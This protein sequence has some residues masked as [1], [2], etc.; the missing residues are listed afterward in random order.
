MLPQPTGRT[1]DCFHT[2]IRYCS[3]LAWLV[4]SYDVLSFTIM[5]ASMSATI[6]NKGLL[7]LGV[8][9]RALDADSL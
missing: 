5:I 6:A 8:P 3:S 1:H 2:R 4:S 9:V 7:A